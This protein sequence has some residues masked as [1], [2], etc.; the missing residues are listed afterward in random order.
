MDIGPEVEQ[1]L[2]GYSWPGNV[3]EMA[4]VMERAVLVCHGRTLN[5]SHLPGRILEVQHTASRVGEIESLSVVEEQHIRKAL[6]L[7]LP[8]DEVARKL[9]ID[10]STLWRKRKRYNL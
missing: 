8:L 9:E 2:I 3:R 7:G 10:P 1:F 5:L 4:H 6:A